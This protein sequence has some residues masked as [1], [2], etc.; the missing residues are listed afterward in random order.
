MFITNGTRVRVSYFKAQTN[1][2]ASL[3]GVMLKFGMTSI[4]FEGTVRHVR[5][6]G[7]T[8]E[9]CTV[10]GVWVQPD[11]DVPAN[12]MPKGNDPMIAGH[13]HCTEC[14]CIEVGP[15]KPEWLKGLSHG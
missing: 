1:P 3:A 12:V 14:N 5:G 15:L 13:A 10:I 4:E 6:D 7:P 11:G 8:P 2:P 9:E